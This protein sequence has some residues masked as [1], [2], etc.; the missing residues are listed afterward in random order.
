MPEQNQLFT[1]ENLQK[2]I[3]SEIGRKTISK[4]EIPEYITANLK[5]S[6]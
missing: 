2:N 4:I 3:E 1:E 5:H 6:F